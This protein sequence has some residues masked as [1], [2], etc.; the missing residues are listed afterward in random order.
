MAATIPWIMGSHFKFRGLITSFDT[1]NNTAQIRG[2]NMYVRL[3][4]QIKML[5]L[6]IKGPTTHYHAT[7]SIILSQIFHFRTCEVTEL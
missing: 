1:F 4:S 5:S 7:E 3:F 6:A 2:E